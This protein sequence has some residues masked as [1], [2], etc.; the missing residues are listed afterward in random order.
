MIICAVQ[1]TRFHSG[2]HD[3]ILTKGLTSF[4]RVMMAALVG[5]SW[6]V[7]RSL[8]AAC[9]LVFADLEGTL[10]V[11]DVTIKDQAFRLTG[12]YTPNDRR[13][14]AAFFRR[15]DPF[16]KTSC[17]VILEG[18]WNAVLDPDIDRTGTRSG[19]NN[20]DVKAFRDFIDR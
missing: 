19:T 4:Q 9:T 3:D 13:E 10:Y 14:W 11:V 8:N 5:G 20:L 1:E 12:V 7:N 16:L 15:I 17:R 2:D 18:D 6:L